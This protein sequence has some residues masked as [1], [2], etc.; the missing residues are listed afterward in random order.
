MNFHLLRIGFRL[1]AVTVVLASAGNAQG[2]RETT[3]Q[4]PE[5]VGEYFL[6][7]A[8]G[9]GL[10]AVV[11]ESGAS[12]QEVVGGSIRLEADGSFVWST[13]YR[14]SERGFV[15]VSESSGRGTY[16]QEGTSIIP[17]FEVGDDAC[18]EG[19]LEGNTLTIQADVAM[20]YR[21]IFG[22]RPTQAF[23]VP[24]QVDGVPPPP[25]W[26]A[27]KRGYVLPATC[28]R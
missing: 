12:R 21:K 15:D 19:T 9:Q 13:R 25:P 5:A 11:S 24:D 22:Q 3:N 4:R 17:K 2:N 26:P 6:V 10:P 14:Y 28:S 16:S 8:N 1:L 27:T 18:C 7:S 23:T 20:V